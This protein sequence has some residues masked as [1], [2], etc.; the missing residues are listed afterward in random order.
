MTERC[1]SIVH[2][3]C[4]E[5]KPMQRGCV[6]LG[7][8][9]FFFFFKCTNDGNFRYKL[10]SFIVQPVSPFEFDFD[11]KSVRIVNVQ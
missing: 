5:N 10:H 4:I 2:D 6:E 9:T 3:T 8:G 7:R 11:L 1:L